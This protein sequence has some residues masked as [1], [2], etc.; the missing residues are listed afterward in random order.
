MDLETY[1]RIRGNHLLRF[2]YLQTGNRH[3]AE[4]L[5]QEVLAD[6][7]RRGDELNDVEDMDAYARRA[8]VN[9]RNSR[10]RRLQRSREVELIAVSTNSN[11]A[12]SEDEW[13]LRMTVWKACRDLPRRQRD[14]VLLRYYMD[15]DYNAI[16]VTLN[17]APSTARSL[18]YRGVEQIK[19][20]LNRE[21]S[22]DR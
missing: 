2:A 13:A 17:C 5:L 7:A 9:R 20:Q 22:Y 14:A 12:H 8:L 1:V 15:L 11:A 10:W 6:L 3:D 21:F 4:D 16:S 19:R 18:V